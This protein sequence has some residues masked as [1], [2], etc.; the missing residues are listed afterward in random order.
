VSSPEPHP[1]AV[2][3]TVIPQDALYEIRNVQ[4]VRGEPTRR[5]FCAD[6]M[7]L[8]VWFDEDDKPVSF[9][10][11]YDR[12]RR[13]ERVIRWNPARG[14]SH[15][16]VDEQRRPSAGSALLLPDG[17]FDAT[18]VRA[19]FLAL[20]PAMPWAVTQY[21]ADRLLAHPEHRSWDSI[22]KPLILAA[23]IAIPLATILAYL[24]SSRAGGR[25]HQD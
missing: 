18:K 17:S 25:R 4:Q 3:G 15:H 14:Y 12:H 23:V 8:I 9:Q 7:D 5:W 13:I 16:R 1:I 11:A 20:S 10:L 19:R 2:A 21:V 24:K 22:R 6:E